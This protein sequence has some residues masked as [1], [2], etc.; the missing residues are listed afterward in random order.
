M[1]VYR[2][3]SLGHTTACHQQKHQPEHKLTHITEAIAPIMNTSTTLDKVL[4]CESGYGSLPCL[5]LGTTKPLICSY[6]SCQ[7]QAVCSW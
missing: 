3:A 5:F 1:W 4:L 6:Q 7:L 2:S